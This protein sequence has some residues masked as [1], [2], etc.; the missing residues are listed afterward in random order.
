MPDVTEVAASAG[1]VLPDGSER[2]RTRSMAGGFIA[3]ASVGVLGGLSGL[4]GA[5]FRLPLLI[6]VF[7]FLAP[8]L[9]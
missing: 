9:E 3:G 4:G 5:E 2:V 8:S 1:A 7:G 6:G